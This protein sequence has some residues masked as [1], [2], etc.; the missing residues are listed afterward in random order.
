MCSN[1]LDILLRRIIYILYDVVEESGPDWQ[2][3]KKDLR[4]KLG[5]DYDNKDKKTE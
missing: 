5:L 1:F 4:K 3:I 2:L